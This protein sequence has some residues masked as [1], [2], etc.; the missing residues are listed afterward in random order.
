ML[1][2]V[3]CFIRII[4]GNFANTKLEIKSLG[5]SVMSNMTMKIIKSLAL[6]LMIGSALGAAAACAMRPKKS[7]F[8]KC[9]GQALEAVGTVMQNISDY[10]F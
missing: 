7:K 10:I 4:V 1:R 5:R 9:A 2:H 3:F 6:G 8:K